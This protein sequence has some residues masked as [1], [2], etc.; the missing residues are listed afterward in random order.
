M[1]D[2]LTRSTTARFNTN[3]VTRADIKT[4]SEVV[5]N[6]T[7]AGIPL[8]IA[9]A[10]VGFEA[11]DPNSSNIAPV[12]EAPPAA[13][14]TRLPPDTRSAMTEIRCD[15]MTTKRRH[16]VSRIEPCNRLLSR[17]GQFVGSC[18]RCKKAF[19]AAVA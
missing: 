11:L 8:E 18:P 3:E 6:L 12:P 16:G 4:R 7:E 9:G 2:L 17:T 13:I 1:S 19:T 14:P 15:G 10:I 5:K